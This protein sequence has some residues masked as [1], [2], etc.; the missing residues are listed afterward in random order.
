M[1]KPQSPFP[2]ELSIFPLLE[3]VFFMGSVVVLKWSIPL[4]ILL[5]LLSSL[6]LSFGI[7]IF[8]HECVH[9]RTL[10]PT[11]FNCAASI[12]LGLPFDGYR[13]HHYNHHAFENGAQDFSTTWK[14]HAES[15]VA[16][17]LCSYTLGWPRQLISSVKCKTPFGGTPDSANQIKARIPAQK[18]ALLLAFMAALLIGWNVFFLYVALIYLGWALTSLHNFGQHPPIEN[19]G[20]PSYL[21]ASYNL[22]FFNNGLHWEHHAFPELHWYALIPNDHSPK[23][24]HAHFI[25]PLL[26]LLL[27]EIKNAR[28]K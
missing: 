3:L 24:N 9:R 16:Y 26:P 19:V 18:I 15:K 11:L 20:I 17:S 10:Y 23:I 1:S 6:S 14:I 8:F 4:A 21:N 12:L 27:L 5:L 28:S 7:H 13:I 22:V 2:W 25:S